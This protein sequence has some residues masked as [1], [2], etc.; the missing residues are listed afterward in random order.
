VNDE[1][2]KDLPD[3]T[4]RL[5]E[6]LPTGAALLRVAHLQ[7]LGGGFALSAVA[8]PLSV[9]SEESSTGGEASLGLRWVHAGRRNRYRL[10]LESGLIVAPWGT[11]NSRHWIPYSA[12]RFRSGLLVV[13]FDVRWAR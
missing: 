13:T 7:P 6:D 8:A 12:L 11:A 3:N 5:L 4:S 1:D 9:V 2:V 10:S